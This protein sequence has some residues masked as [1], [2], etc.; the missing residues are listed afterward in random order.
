MPVVPEPTPARS[1]VERL[2]PRSAAHRMALSPSVAMAYATFPVAVVTD[3]SRM[4]FLEETEF[5]RSRRPHDDAETG[6]MCL[7]ALGATPWAGQ[8]VVAR[9]ALS[10]VNAVLFEF[11][12]NA[13]QWITSLSSGASRC[14]LASAR[15]RSFFLASA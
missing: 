10:Q 9:P 3:P 13:H 6:I 7:L 4:A 2:M 8:L 5:P 12:E 1:K 15:A 11:I 14:A